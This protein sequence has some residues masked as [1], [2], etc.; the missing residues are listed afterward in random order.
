MFRRSRRGR[1]AGGGS[2]GVPHDPDSMNALG[3]TLTD[4]G[5]LDEAAYMRQQPL[6]GVQQSRTPESRPRA[7]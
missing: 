1:P 3:V 6:S 5:R 2:N 4:E 7:L